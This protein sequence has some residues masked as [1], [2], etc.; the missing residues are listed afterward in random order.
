MQPRT[1]GTRSGSSNAGCLRAAR[2][3]LCATMLASALSGGALAVCGELWIKG[4]HEA[5]VLSVLFVAV[6]F[7]VLAEAGFGEMA[8][9]RARQDAR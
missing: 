4:A 6:C 8:L 7:Y 2:R 9:R 3:Y 5:V 1:R